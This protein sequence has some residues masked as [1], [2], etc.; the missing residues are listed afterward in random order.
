M[1]LLRYGRALAVCLFA[2]TTCLLPMA[3]QTVPVVMLS[4]IHFDPFHDPARFDRLRSAPVTQWQQIFS[5]PDAPTQAADFSGLMDKCK[6]RGVD[7]PWTLLQSTLAAAHAQSPHP[8]FVTVSGDLL[9]HKFDCRFHALAHDSSEA[10]YSSFAAKTIAY[11]ASELRRAFP[12]TPLYLA[13]GNNDAGC[14][15][16]REAQRLRSPSRTAYSPRATARKSPPLFPSAAITA[17]RFPA[18]FSAAV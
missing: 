2:S 14:G 17:W 15:D 8:L 5:E 6:A 3:A 13:L 18:R 16:Y 12:A 1:P 9:V 11:V 4:D 7:T 10:E